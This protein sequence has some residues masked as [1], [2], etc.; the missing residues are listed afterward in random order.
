[1]RAEI[2][3]LLKRRG[4]LS[5]D[6][7]ACELRISKVA[8]RRHLELLEERGLVRHGAERCERGRPRHIYSLT[9]NGDGLFP[10][11][12]SQFACSLLEQIG[13]SLGEEAVE[14]ILSDRTDTV[15]QSLRAELEGLPFEDRVLA[16]AKRFNE[17]G[18]VA[19]VSRLDDGSFRVVE[20]NCPTREIAAKFPRVCEEELRIFSEVAGARVYR[21]CRISAGGSTC[22][23]RIA[24]QS[25]TGRQLPILHGRVAE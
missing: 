24:P 12:S 23:Y 18:Y 6:L 25:G 16:L 3:N 1:M 4:G 14:R 21:D 10:D 2:V 7:L 13:A 11:T 15:I 8:V 9:A 5:A 17:M 19:D 20:H 22:E